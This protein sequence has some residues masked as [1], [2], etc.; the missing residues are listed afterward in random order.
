MKAKQI[1]LPL[2]KLLPKAKS[3]HTC[4]QKVQ[5][6]STVFILLK[7]LLETPSREDRQGM[8]RYSHQGMGRIKER[9]MTRKSERKT[10]HLSYRSKLRL[11]IQSL[12]LN[13]N[14]LNTGQAKISVLRKY[15]IV[16]SPQKEKV[17]IARTSSWMMSL[18]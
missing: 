5:R 18:P 1:K 17:G 6:M 15:R 9:Q 12:L 14:L 2:P 10:S 11:R 7:G 16:P 3:K 13:R 4:S 8:I